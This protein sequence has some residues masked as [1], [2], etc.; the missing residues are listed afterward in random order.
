MFAEIVAKD[1]TRFG[2]KPATS[3]ILTPTIL[4]WESIGIINSREF[5]TFTDAIAGTARHNKN[6]PRPE[7]TITGL[8]IIDSPKNNFE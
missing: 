4:F 2:K 6:R 7:E 5:E 1:G 8:L 3:A